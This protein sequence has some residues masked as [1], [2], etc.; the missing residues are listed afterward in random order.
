MLRCR[1]ND[2]SMI[3]NRRV[4]Q[5]RVRFDGAKRLFQ[6]GVEET[7]IELVF[8]AVLRGERGIRLYDRHQCCTRVL[9]QCMKKTL[10]MAVH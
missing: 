6:I 7:G 9:R 10:H 5:D 3:L 8:R 2:T 1:D 4:N